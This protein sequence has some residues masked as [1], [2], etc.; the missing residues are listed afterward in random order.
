MATDDR[1]IRV[2]DPHREYGL[3]ITPPTVMTP[4]DVEPE[5]VAPTAPRRPIVDVFPDAPAPSIG[6]ETAVMAKE[7]L[8]AGFGRTGAQPS[9]LRNLQRPRTYEIAP[10]PT[11]SPPPGPVRPRGPDGPTA[12]VPLGP[13]GR[14]VVST[15]PGDRGTNGG[16]PYTVDANGVARIDT[17]TNTQY[18]E[19]FVKG[20]NDLAVR[21]PDLVGQRVNLL[22]LPELRDATGKYIG[23]VDHPEWSVPTGDGFTGQRPNGTF[24]VNGHQ[25]N[26][27]HENDFRGFFNR[28]ITAAGATGPGTH[29]PL[30]PGATGTPSSTGAAGLDPTGTTG[31]V[32]R[33]GTPVMPNGGMP[34]GTSTPVH[35]GPAGLITTT[36]DTK[37]A[38]LDLATGARGA[39]PLGAKPAGLPTTDVRPSANLNSTSTTSGLSRPAGLQTDFR[40]ARTATFADGGR[41]GRPRAGLEPGYADGG[42]LRDLNLNDPAVRASLPEWLRRQ[43]VPVSNDENGPQYGFNGMYDQQGRQVSWVA[44]NHTATDTSQGDGSLRDPSNFWDDPVLGRVTPT[45]N[46]RSIQSASFRNGLRAVQAAIAIAGGYA[47]YLAA[48][49]PAGAAAAAEVGITSEATAQAALANAGMVDTLGAGTAAD[50]FAGSNLGAWGGAGLETAGGLS[51]SIDPNLLTS[52]GF[53]PSAANVTTL[54]DSPVIQQA[55][56]GAGQTVSQWLSNPANLARAARMVGSLV[57]LGANSNTN[58]GNV[59]LI[60]P[61]GT[62][63][64][65]PPGGP[66]ATAAPP[67]APVA[68]TRTPAPDTDVSLDF[69]DQLD[70]NQFN[71][72]PADLSRWSEARGRYRPIEDMLFDESMK[73]GSAAEQE[74]AAGRAGADTEQAFRAAEEQQRRRLL[75]QGVNPDDGRG[76]GAELSRMATLDKAKAMAGGKNVA[77]LTEKERGRAARLAAA[78]LGT[79]IAGQALNADQFVEQSAQANDRL[80]ADIT[81]RRVDA[82]GRIREGNATRRFN[83]WDRT[84]DRDSREYEGDATRAVTRYG[85]D[86]TRL[87]QT[88][89]NALDRDRM[90]LDRDRLNADIQSGNFNRDRQNRIDTGRGIGQGIGTALDIYRAGT[91]FGW[92]NKGGRVDLSKIGLGT[93]VK[94]RKRP[95]RN[96]ADGARVSIDRKNYDEGGEVRGPGTTTS[97]SIKAR[98]SDKEGVL[99]AE[100]MEILDE[101]EPDKFDQLNEMGLRVREVRKAM[102]AHHAGLEA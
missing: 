87:T 97:D 85:I 54:V 40:P 76:P 38:G 70:P 92:W 16:T 100:A 72:G 10:T 80:R 21:R 59:P 79:T 58:N 35:T 55:A 75:A 29:A 44:D 33:A 8:P 5:A 50:G 53:E 102:K 3:P 61:P 52:I 41:V 42:R 94:P 84:E 30:A 98:L 6:L 96:Y 19:Q 2:V 32:R 9:N 15:T 48:T 64:T 7:T 83:T 63:T 26:G 93:E 14:P 18:R 78:G 13:D 37:P 60:P 43:I 24:A 90:G 12:T 62:T 99:N 45:E 4:N 69:L 66:P 34:G 36:P 91:D 65:P 39:D 11:L 73:A 22:D 86:T 20:I 71:R 56:A 46:M 49:G 88:E 23:P 25:F 17:G 47:A 89:R 57:S 95:N 1:Q 51:R 67:P 81:G 82:E 101:T 68:R 74:A 31:L 77:R 28:E 27:N